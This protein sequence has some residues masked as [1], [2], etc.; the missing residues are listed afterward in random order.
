M[1][2]AGEHRRQVEPET[3]HVHLQNPVPQRVHHQLQHLRMTHLQAIPAAA[4][5]HVETGVV[6]AQPVV[7]GAVDTAEAQGRPEMVAF[8]GVVIHDVQE[9]LD[10]DR[11][12]R[13]D[14][15]LELSH[16]PATVVGGRITVVRGEVADCVVA[17]VVT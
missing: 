9:D 5:V 17:P 16:L 10:P 6:V 11:V 3:V 7:R 12:Q 8:A 15:R 13:L 14:H 1:Q 4:V 2:L